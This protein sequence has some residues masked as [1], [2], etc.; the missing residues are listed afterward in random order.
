VDIEGLLGL[1]GMHLVH[2]SKFHNSSVLSTVEQHDPV[3]QIQTGKPEDLR[4]RSMCIAMVDTS[5]P[6]NDAGFLSYG[7][8]GPDPM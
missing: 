4:T 6:R 7:C 8:V 2:L 3:P 5:K 1:G